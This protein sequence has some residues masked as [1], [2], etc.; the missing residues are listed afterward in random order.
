MKPYSQISLTILAAALG[1]ALFVG[2]LLIGAYYYVAPGLPNAAEL[3]DIKIQVPLQIYSRD[4]RLIDEFGEMKRTPVVYGDVPPLLVKAVLATEDEHFF[5]HPG[6]DYRGIIRAALSVLTGNDDVGGSTITQQVPRTLDVTK[7]AG[8]NSGFDRFVAKYKEWILAFRMEQEFTKEEILELYLN[9]SF[10][11]QRSYGI[12]TAAQTYF[13]K[14]LGE[15]TVAEIA[16]LAGIPQRPAEW[17]PVASTERARARRSYV[18]RRMR[19]T[20]AISVEEEQ[21]ALDEPI[22]GKEFGLQ[23]QLEAPYLAEMVRAEMVRRFGSAAT[24]AGLKVTTTID[25]RLQGAA[26]RAIRD[27]LMAYDERHGY[28]GPLGHVELPNPVEAAEDAP[29]PAHVDAEALRELLE[30]EDYGPLLDYETA[31]VLAADDVTA[32]VFFATHGVQSI[33]FDAV[34]WASRFISDES[35]G[36]APATVAEVLQPGDVVRFRRTAE[37]GWRLAQIPEVQGAFVSIDPFDGAIVALNG[38]FDFFLNNFNRATQA[39]RQPGSSFKPFVYSAA[40]EHGFTPATV[41][42]DAPPDVGYQPTLERVWR[43][44]NFNGKYYGPSRLREA[45]YE[46]MNAVSIKLVQSIGVPAAVQ[47]VKRFGFDNEAVPNDLSLALGAGT[48]APLTVAA[49]YAT[50]ANG[51]YKVAPYFIDRVTT[52]DGE[53]IYESKPALCAECNTPPETPVQREPVAPDLVSDITE[54]YPKQRAAPRVI[55]PQNAYLVSDMLRDVITRGSGGRALTLGRR[56]LAGKTGTT[57]EGR[58]TW[59]VGFNANLIG[60]AWVGFDQFRPLGGNEQGGRTAIPMWIDYMRE[61]LAGTPER[62]PSRPPGIVE[63]RI[64]PKTGLIAGDDTFDSIFEKFDI[65][66]LPEREQSSGFVA[67][68]DSFDS[69]AGA[70]P[71]GEPIF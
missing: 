50:F 32:D 41:V 28:R 9:T 55:S 69:G 38:G 52:V 12:A 68:L 67:P 60:A 66:H 39:R 18:L 44:E 54:L 4:G 46:S 33:G 13:G 19:E 3:R 70:R 56:D 26:N 17:N 5:E 58:D 36:P 35:K 30:V 61:A 16:V 64:N 23:R 37:G 2:A 6:I 45:L 71:A 65:D 20:A 51:G 27:T 10:F 31:I 11:G 42:L 1:S 47:H 22:L 14:T 49:G 57:N 40:F 21:A 15:L 7:R 8:L 34:E 62:L 43:P 63:Y 29:G 25:S 24:T 53:V 59:F 48:V